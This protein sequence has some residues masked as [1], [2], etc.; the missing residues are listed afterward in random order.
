MAQFLDIHTIRCERCTIEFTDQ[1]PPEGSRRRFRSAVIEEVDFKA[2]PRARDA[3]VE[4]KLVPRRRKPKNSYFPAVMNTIREGITPS[5]NR[6]TSL[7][8]PLWPQSG[9][10]SNWRPQMPPLS[11]CHQ[12]PWTGSSRFQDI[13]LGCKLPRFLSYPRN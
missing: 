7:V 5:R 11:E 9:A 2:T 6:K 3:R 10:R 13:S 12:L 4:V 1:L 8:R